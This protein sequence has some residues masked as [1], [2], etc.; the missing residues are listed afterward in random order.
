MSV[1]YPRVLSLLFLFAALIPV[2][3]VRWRKS[4]E[5]AAIF[6]APAPRE[7]RNSALKEL[8]LRMIFSDI[9]FALFAALLVIALA[10][11]HWG[12]RIVPD[13]RRGVDVVLAFDVSR[14]MDVRDSPPFGA[15]SGHPA[16]E[17]ISRLQRGAGIAQ[18]LVQTIGDEVRFATA[19]GR[20]RGVLAVPLT[21]DPEMVLSFL[22]TLDSAGVTGR[23]TNLQSIIDA[24]STSFQDA[25]PTRRVII[26]FSDGEEHSG[27]FQEAVERARRAGIAVSAVAL[28][29]AEGGPVPVELG[30][31]APDGL[32]L[33][34][35]GTVVISSRRSAALVSGADRTGGVYV[36]GSRPDAAQ[37]LAAHI[38]SIYA[39]TRLL[40]HRREPNP[41]WRVFVIAAMMCLAAAKLM[42]FT[43]RGAG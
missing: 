7:E 3:A 19:I 1:D 21:Y 13:F 10:G 28:G 16:P 18:E 25:I 32:L 24:A 30:P 36:S 39:E 40:G 15:G 33:R 26:L 5:R 9:F 37:V 12:Q 38:A 22:Y 20:G 31:S 27:S 35:D 4:R 17:A 2:L 34:A 23:G 43:R 14:S 8:R 6:A 11:P 42:G 41:R 29:T